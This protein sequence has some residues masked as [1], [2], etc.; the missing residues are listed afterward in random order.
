MFPFLAKEKTVKIRF[1]FDIQAENRKRLTWDDLETIE[2]MQNGETSIKGLKQLAAR[3][4]ADEK[5]IY[6]PHE[7]ALKVLGKLGAD[8]ISDVLRKF[9]EALQSAAVNP[10]NGN[11]SRS[12]SEAGQAA[13]TL[14]AGPAS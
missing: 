4:M 2:G 1:F 7:Q 10:Q 6:L 8:E 11:G 3:F 5:N 14:P 12:P 9:T 13:G